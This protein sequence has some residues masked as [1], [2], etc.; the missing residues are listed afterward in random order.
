MLIGIAIDSTGI[1]VTN[2]GPQWMQ[3]EK[4]QVKKKK[5][6]YLKIYIAVDINTKEIYSL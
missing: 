3:Q 2:R 4:W 6:G 5:K 1:K